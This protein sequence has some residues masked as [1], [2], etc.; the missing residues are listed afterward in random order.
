MLIILGAFQIF[1]VPSPVLAAVPLIV[2]VIITAI[3]DAIEDSRRT[4]TD[5][6]VN[7]Q[8]THILTQVD[9]EAD[10]HYE[11]VNVND[12]KV[13]LWRRFKK[14]NTKQM[15]KVWGASRRNLT[16]E[17]R[18]N[19]ERERYNRENNIVEENVRNSFDSDVGSPRPSMDVNPFSDQ[20]RKSFQQQRQEAH[21]H[22][23]K[24]LK[25]ARKYWKDVK[26]GDVLRIYNNEEVPA[27]MVILSTS[28]DDNCCFV[29][30]KILMVKQT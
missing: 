25:F 16:K 18:A 29:E 26:V 21:Q 2:I 28:D 3:K 9:N 5:L 6:E 7:N 27:D 15:V 20:L 8:F 13:S 24:I 23:H 17:G 12:E 30:T 1:G 11:N 10:Y 4:I 22:H 14:W 19:K